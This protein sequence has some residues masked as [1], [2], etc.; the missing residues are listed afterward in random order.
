M[1]ASCGNGS[2][3]MLN[4]SCLLRLGR[5]STNFTTASPK[6]RKSQKC[7]GLDTW[8]GPCVSIRSGL[9]S[10]AWMS[11]IGACVSSPGSTPP[12][13]PLL[14]SPGTPSASRIAP[15]CHLLGPKQNSASAARSNASDGSRL[16]L[17][18]PATSAPLW[19][20][21]HRSSGRFDLYRHDYRGP[22]CSIG[23]SSRLD[24]LTQKG[25]GS[26]LGGLLNDAMPSQ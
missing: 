9:A 11:P 22:G 5:L 3:S 13:M 15:A 23:W 16:P 14:S 24:P 1:R 21:H 25:F 10:S 20:V 7:V 2:S 17:L 19:L 18:S 12:Y 8:N 6:T 26:C 4:L